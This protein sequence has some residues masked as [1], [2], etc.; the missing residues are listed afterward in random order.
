MVWSQV[1]WFSLIIALVVILACG[2]G[3]SGTNGPRGVL[4]TW[5]GEMPRNRQNADV[6]G[7]RAVFNNVDGNLT[8]TLTLTDGALIVTGPLTGKQIDEN[9]QF[10]STLD[11]QYGFVTFNAAQTSD[12]SLV[13]TWIRNSSAGQETGTLSASPEQ[14][15]TTGGTT[16]TTTGSTTGGGTGTGRATITIDSVTY[17]GDAI[18][19]TTGDSNQNSIPDTLIVMTSPQAPGEIFE[20][21]VFDRIPS[22]STYPLKY[23]SDTSTI[24]SS[25]FTFGGFGA[26]PYA[27]ANND[28]WQLLTEPGPGTGSVTFTEVSSN[29]IAGSINGRFYNTTVQDSADVSGTFDAIP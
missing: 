24:A 28:D 1:K 21:F 25:L 14:N 5:I 20:I 7:F 9:V 29:R 4:G 19:S 16:G 10:S 8:G 12:T 15:T 18:F 13:G 26:D 17:T 3:G 27:V 23:L 11:Q 2:G 22:T 6:I